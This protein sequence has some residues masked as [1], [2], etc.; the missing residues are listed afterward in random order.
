M[1]RRQ[2]SWVRCIDVIKKAEKLKAGE[3]DKIIKMTQCDAIDNDEVQ[4]KDRALF[5]T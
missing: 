2:H 5:S 4:D 1:G 3:P